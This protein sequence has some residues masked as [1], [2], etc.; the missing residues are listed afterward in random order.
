F[1]GVAD[2]KRYISG[3]AIDP[4]TAE[5]SNVFAIAADRWTPEHPSQNAF[6]PRLAYG[7]ANNFNNYQM[8]SWWVKDISFMRLKTAQLSYNLPTTFLTR[9]G[10][11]NA[12]VYLQGL[13]LLTFSKF[14]LWDP[15]LNT[16][17]GNTY[18]NVRTIT[19]GVNFKF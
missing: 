17:N 1:Q 15:E 9:W 8:S 7:N 13:N 16:G 4:F 6:Y 2:A 19:M 12:A 18:P 10:V 3:D 5:Q 11:K 14:K